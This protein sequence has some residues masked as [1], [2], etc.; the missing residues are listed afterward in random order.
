ITKMASPKR[1][2]LNALD[3]IMPRFFSSLIFTFR[4][5]KEATHDQALQL[6]QESLRTACDEL[7]YFRR[8]VFSIPISPEN[9][10]PG[11]LE[12]R[13]HQDWIPQVLRNDLTK[14]WPEYDDMVEDGLPQDLLDGSQ[15][16]PP[17]RHIIDL[18]HEGTPLLVA[19]ANYVRGG[20]LLG[21]SMFHSLVDG[22]SGALILRMW[23]KHMRIHSGE[24]VAAFDISPGSC[25]YDTL[26]EV[27]KTSGAPV[28][29][30]TPD[31]WRL[32]GL[33]PPGVE[34]RP[35]GAPP[36]PMR[37][38][39]F[40]IS[41]T[42]F[43]RLGAIAAGSSTNGHVDG[44]GAD[45]DDGVKLGGTANDALMALLWRCV[46]RARRAA[47]PESPSYGASEVAELDTTLNGRAF[48][49][50]ELPWQYMG[51]LVYIVT[52]RMTVAELTDPATPLSAVVSAVRNSVAR[53]TRE[54]ALSVYGLA[55]TRLEGYTAETLRW[56]FATFE[57]AEACFS[58][59]VSLPVM[60]ISFGGKVFAG[61]GVPD[62]VRPERRALD[63]VCRNCNILPLRLE[64]GTE[65]FIS[66]TVD[67][68]ALLER[69][70]EFAEYAQLVCH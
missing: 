2:A 9:K 70:A 35:S 5:S 51:T 31:D 66:L 43:A 36:P 65:V 21:V 40:Y 17:G 42:S 50:E 20:L 22:M 55:A 60:D 58:S 1:F 49:G 16:F 45:G 69:D 47:A 56:P 62:Y 46:M 11:R 8:K 63:H 23:A 64:G 15:L 32:L 41:G 27:W 4:L 7:P 12:A 53:V 30:G 57:G 19:Q 26:H 13:E 44:G 34:D 61:N 28:A 67:E 68:M 14:S 24:T 54:R 39:I 48:F 10:T 3:N 59:L 6:L 37:S 52:T 38:S 29:E 25:D 33:L 18:D